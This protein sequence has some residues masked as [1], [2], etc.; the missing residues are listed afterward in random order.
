MW[1]IEQKTAGNVG[2]IRFRL[3]P[4]LRELTKDRYAESS[5]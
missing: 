1:G 3:F 4:D 5:E 2:K